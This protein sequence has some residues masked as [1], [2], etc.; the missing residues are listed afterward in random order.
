MSFRPRRLVHNSLGS[1]VA[2]G[3][4]IFTTLLVPA[5]L[6]RGL[7]R[8][9]FDLFLFVLAVLPAL[10]I[11]PQSMRTV[12]ATHLA[13][14]SAEYGQG[15]AVWG[16]GRST[17]TV[18]AVHSLLCV[19]GI[20]AYL[21]FGGLGH[22]WE[23]IARFGLYSLF[24]YTLGLFV[25]GVIVAPPAAERDFRP[26]NVAKLWPGA[27]QLL[28][29]AAVWQARPAEP[30]FWVFIVYV[31]SSWS[32]ALALFLRYGRSLAQIA[33]SGDRPER[34]LQRSLITRLRGVVWWNGTAFLATSATVVVMALGHPASLAPFSLAMSL[35]G[36]VSA[37]LIAISGP[38]AVHATAIAG[39]GPAA[40]RRFFVL[41]NS[42]FQLYILLA[43][44]V[45][46]FLPTQILA[47]WLNPEL[48]VGVKSFSLLLLPAFVLRLL[49]MAFTVF[50]M[51]AGRQ[52]TLW[53]SPMVEAGL[54]TVGSIV[55]S[56]W[57]GPVGIPVALTISA[58]VRLGMTLLHDDPINRTHL[59]L[60]RHDLL[61]SV[62]H[63]RKSR[64]C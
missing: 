29:I 3:L 53:L 19:I 56:Y 40:R 18:V 47:F 33:S 12:G 26:D 27:F 4:L 51:A 24:A 17:V 23:G 21:A 62:M 2:S 28:G 48:A 37:G 50:V 44:L 31:T 43:A 32:L 45:V 15:P 9:E 36:I 42:F 10:L 58:A 46:A 54:S 14:A 57:M 61:F 30:L 38:I 25:V 64:T 16:L 1:L 55:L 49:T 34:G 52:H 11:I 13:L 35:L 20:E 63:L 39:E 5:I 8:S 22:E 7:Q 41:T 59:G 60:E 6:T